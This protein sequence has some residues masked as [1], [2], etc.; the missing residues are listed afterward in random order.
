V[1]QNDEIYGNVSFGST[2]SAGFMVCGTDF[3]CNNFKV[4]NNTISATGAWCHVTFGTTG[5]GNLVKNNIFYDCDKA[6]PIPAGS[7]TLDYNAYGS[8]TTVNGFE[9]S[10]NVQTNI[11]SSY[12]TSTTNFRLTKNTTAGANL[13]AGYNTDMIGTTR[14]LW[15][16]GAYEYQA[17][18]T[19][20]RSWLP[21]GVVESK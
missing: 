16:R 14:T 17:A 4:Y 20:Y 10:S 2:G 5:T 11:D 15:D 18:A 8:I 12:F 21:S 6:V 13:G 19:S 1:N 3:E 7:Y 9:G